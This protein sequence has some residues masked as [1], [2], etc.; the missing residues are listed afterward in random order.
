MKVSAFNN[1]NYPAFKSKYSSPKAYIHDGEDYKLITT[2]Q[3]YEKCKKNEYP[4]YCTYFS[5]SDTA[6]KELKDLAGEYR[7]NQSVENK[8]NLIKHERKMLYEELK[9]PDLTLA[10]HYN[11]ITR[12]MEGNGYE[13]KHLDSIITNLNLMAIRYIEGL[14]GNFTQEFSK[15][16][17]DTLKEVSTK[18]DESNPFG[19]KAKDNVNKIIYT[20]SKKDRNFDNN[21]ADVKDYIS[22]LN[23]NIN[24]PDI[25][26]N[27]LF[28]SSKSKHN[29]IGTKFVE[30]VLESNPSDEMKMYAVWGAGKFRSDKNFKTIKNI[31]LNPNEKNILLREYAIHSTALYLKDKPKEVLNI[32]DKISKDGQVFAPL[33]QIIKDKI[34]GKYHNQP[35]REFKYKKVTE[36]DKKAVENFEQNIIYDTKI[37]QN[38]KN[39]IQRNLII[40]K[41]IFAKNKNKFLKTYISNDTYTKTNPFMAG[42]RVIYDNMLNS[43]FN[44]TIKGCR[45][46]SV[47]INDYSLKSDSSTSCLAHEMGHN[48]MDNIFDK[49]DTKTINKLFENATNKGIIKDQYAGI[50]AQEY[51]A[52]GCQSLASTYIPHKLLL[53]ADGK[54]KYW[55]IA[56]DPDLFKFI[57]NCLKKY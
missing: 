4:S 29:E 56:K 37:N 44:D 24:Q 5:T 30:K 39:T 38:N 9:H 55:L 23:D 28:H 10:R 34:T 19:V 45:A 16:N 11:E 42:G 14:K 20:L 13:S 36:T 51:F 26:R 33:G 6:L 43:C 15:E 52:C 46:E 31:A 22:K 17:L 57:R 1:I 49:E 25:F 32:M 48:L 35:D 27:F 53:S 2:E 18:I 54:S 21:T 50:N 12:R 47:F 40:Y 7:K 3:L 41:D 8:K